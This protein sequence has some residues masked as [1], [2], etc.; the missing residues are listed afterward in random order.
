VAGCARRDP[1]RAALSAWAHACPRPLALFFDEIDALRGARLVS[2][3][4]QLRDGFGERPERFPASV[5][6]C[7]LRD[8]R[9]YK[10]DT[11]WREDANQAYVGN[12]Q[13]AM[14]T[15]PVD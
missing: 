5:A 11:V 13:Q 15:L 4:R 10:A 2:V 6:L 9:D 1:A 3:L 14:A 12:G 7:G 8:V